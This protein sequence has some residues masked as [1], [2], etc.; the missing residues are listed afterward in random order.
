MSKRIQVQGKHPSEKITGILKKKDGKYY[1]QTKFDRN[2]DTW[3]I[4]LEEILEEFEDQGITLKVQKSPWGDG[5]FKKPALGNS[6]EFSDIQVH[7]DYKYA[8]P[9]AIEK[10][11]DMKF[12]MMIH[13]GFYSQLGV[14]ESWCAHGDMTE[15]EFFDIYYTL[16]QVFNPVEFDANE[17]VELAKIAGMQFFQFTTKHHDGF[18]MFD[19]KTKT[20][21]RKRLSI[22]GPMVGPVEDVEINFSIMD[23]LFKRDIVK[24]LVDAFRKENLGVGLYYSN[25]DWND[26]NFRWTNGHRMYDPDYHPDSHP[27]E[28]QAFIKRQKEQMREIFT[29]YGPIDQVFF[30]ASWPNIALKDM[31]ELILMSRQLQPNCMMSDRGLGP[32]GDF[33]S[34]ERWIPEDDD[35]RFKDKTQKLWQVCDPIHGSWAYLPE[36]K[37]KDDIVLLKNLVNAISKGGT[38]VFAVSPMSNGKFPQNTVNILKYM[39]NWLQKYGESI[40]YT[41]KWDKSKE[42]DQ[43][44]FYTQS[45]DHKYLYM[46]QF[47]PYTEKIVVDKIQIKADTK[48]GLLG[49]DQQLSWSSVEDKIHITIPLEVLKVIENEDAIALKIELNQ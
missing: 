12:G 1:I 5:M 49:V 19:T 9:E 13:W 28:W 45:K 43:D 37:Y 44:I 8:S 31:E 48:I 2:P 30:D 4:P 21:A 29:N 18:C 26:P 3:E 22:Q 14:T 42:K 16:W 33:T 7:P 15:Q 40:Y 34:P 41:R 25:I 35:K 6:I 32:Y 11:Q 23:T 27:D 39:G 36:D 24:E 10:F 38:Y 47:G 17:W 20:I 46:I